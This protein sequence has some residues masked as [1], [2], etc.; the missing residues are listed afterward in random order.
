MN[1]DP[2]VDDRAGGD[3]PDPILDLLATSAKWLLA[4]P[5]PKAFVER[6]VREGPTRFAEL[7]RVGLDPD[8]VLAV[9]LAAASPAAAAQDGRFFRSLGWAIASAM[10]LPENGFRARRLPMPGRNDA[11]VCGSG[12][13]FKQCCATFFAHLPP[14]EPELLMALVVRALPAA[15]WAGLPRFHVPPDAVA[16]AA[17]LLCNEGRTGEALALLLPWAQ[18][19]APWPDGRA[20]L[21]DFL[22]DLYLDLGMQPERERLANGMIKHGGKVMQ[23]LGWQ[24]LCLMAT[25]AGDDRAARDAFEKAQRLTPNDPR[26]ALLEVT[27]LLGRGESDRARERAAFHLKRLSRLPEAQ[28][29]SEHLAAL[30]EFAD[31]ESELS[32]RSDSMF[33]E[34]ALPSAPLRKLAALEEWLAA[35][36]APKLRLTLP[37]A[38]CADL[39]ELRPNAAAK[40]ALRQ[41]HAAFG[42]DAPL[43][44]WES[45]GDQ[46][47]LD[48]F[49]CDEWLPLLQAQPL[50]TD[51]FEV[52][53]G[54]NLMLEQVPLPEAASVRS[55]LLTRALDL[56]QLV[57]VRHPNALCEWAWLG[58]RPALR[59]LAWRSQIDTSRKADGSFEWLQY[60][61]NVLNPHDNHGLRQRLAAVYLRRGEDAQALA[62]CERYPDDAPG[63]SLLHARALLAAERLPD[64]SKL[65]DQALE[66]NEH[67]RKLLLGSR[68][69]RRPDV[70]S[71]RVGSL[72]EARVTLSD[73]FDLWRDDLAVRKW[74]REKLEAGAASPPG[75]LGLFD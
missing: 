10:P 5:D 22:G 47:A 44:S 29:M 53:D 21:L 66:R 42:F 20:D 27:A 67:L 59:L 23:S 43:M 8:D 52:I 54:L 30:A 35:L 9:S 7:L 36:P 17:E 15:Q 1:D 14:L 2:L 19:P 60:L 50:L 40:K 51:C 33:R 49:D 31:A 46:E 69:P 26:V 41:W 61:V 13:K 34:A 65:L 28:S 12:A 72:E 37:A 16:A 6:L 56:W 68:A 70:P 3:E 39:G 73:Q 25:D 48:A 18:L 57:R 58:N 32:R 74:L 24:R 4:D 75:S 62:L 63:M 64:A 11:C 71:Y 55:L 45:A 38:P